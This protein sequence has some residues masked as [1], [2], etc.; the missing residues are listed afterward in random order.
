MTHRAVLFVLAFF[1]F[2]GTAALH[3]AEPTAAP[4]DFGV[5]AETPQAAQI[6][7][8][9]PESPTP[10]AAAENMDLGLV[11]K[12]VQV[13]PCDHWDSA[14]CDYSRRSFEC[15]KAVILIPNSYCPNICA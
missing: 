2:A 15:C 14:Y 10:A 13:G 6:D 5:C 4:A 3:A 12:C 1:L 8:G 9:Q 11:N 7:A